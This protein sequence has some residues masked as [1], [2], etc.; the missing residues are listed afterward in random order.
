[1]KVVLGFI[2]LLLV[3]LGIFLH[4]LPLFTGGSPG[5]ARSTHSLHGAG[6]PEGLKGL[7]DAA[8]GSLGGE[9]RGGSESWLIF[10]GFSGV[11]RWFSW[12]L[13]T[14]LVIFAELLTFYI[15]SWGF[16][17]FYKAF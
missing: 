8:R 16:M 13:V 11:S 17:R 4:L 14:G 15:F 5:C 1:M 2:F 3:F 9:G 7:L 6:K 10:G 12:V